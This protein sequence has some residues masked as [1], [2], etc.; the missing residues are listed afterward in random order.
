MNM[1]PFQ[2]C[3]APPDG[4]V[5]V[6]ERVERAVGSNGDDVLRGPGRFVASHSG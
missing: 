4:R 3:N 5:S 2:R 6:L 1:K